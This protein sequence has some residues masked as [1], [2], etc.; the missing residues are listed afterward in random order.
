MN[1]NTPTPEA[2]A[3][4]SNVFEELLNPVIDFVQQQDAN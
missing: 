4:C 2:P 3:L 1:S